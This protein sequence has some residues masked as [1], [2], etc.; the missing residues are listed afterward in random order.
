MT[1]F[2]KYFNRDSNMEL[3]RILAMFGIL[4]VHADYF[5]LGAPTKADCIVEPYSSACRFSIESLTIVSVNLFVMLSGWY[6]IHP[7]K[8][9]FLEFLFQIF[10]FNILFFFAFSFFIPDKTFTPKGIGSLFMLDSRFWF[11]KAYLL[12]YIISPILNAFTDNANKK[13]YTYVLM[14]FY[15][16]QFLYGWLFSSVLW[17]K[18]GYSTISFVGIYLLADYFHR[19]D[20]CGG[21]NK[22]TLLSIFLLF[23]AVNSLMLFFSS[24]YFKGVLDQRLI[25]YNSP[26]VIIAT[27]AV[28]LF[29]TKINI[30]RNAIINY[31]AA[32]SF[33]AFLFMEI[34]SFLMKSM[35]FT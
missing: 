2:K 4:V 8:K 34:I 11:V 10:F 23:V 15:I 35:C 29:F 24:Y 6:G 31:I 18:M 12:L 1:I 30:K 5:A 13:H 3:L 25:A 7:K 16:F 27:V 26:L 28:F 19:Y 21:V 32:S 17:F 20:V 33:A 22:K 14:G 9:R